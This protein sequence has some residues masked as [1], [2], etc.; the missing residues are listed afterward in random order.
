MEAY[1]DD[2]LIK[3]QSR[4]DHLTHLREAFQLMRLHP[5]QL[6]PNKRTFR[7]ESKKF[8]GFLMRKRGIEMAP[9]Q[10]KAI[11]HMQT[12]KT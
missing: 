7:V 6:N 11:I 4:E 5:L 12:P 2:M 9:E 3:S 1:N 8:L 10:F